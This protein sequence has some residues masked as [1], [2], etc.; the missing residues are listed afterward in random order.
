MK[1][2]KG[3]GANLELVVLVV[4]N[5]APQPARRTRYKHGLVRL[6]WTY[7]DKLLCVRGTKKRLNSVFFSSDMDD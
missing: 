5:D 4:G 1:S 2:W 3:I 6:C 7:P